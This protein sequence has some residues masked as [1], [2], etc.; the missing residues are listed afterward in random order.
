VGEPKAKP[1]EN[2]KFTQAY[3]NAGSVLSIL[4]FSLHAIHEGSALKFSKSGRRATGAPFAFSALVGIILIT[5]ALDASA[6][7]KL[8]F[9]WRNPTYAGGSFKNI[10]VLAVNGQASRRADFEDAM[11]STLSRPGVQAV[12]SYVFLA[13]PDATPIDP[14][15]L[16][17]IVQSQHFDAILVARLTKYKKTQTYVEGDAVALPP[18]LVTFYGYYAAVTPVVYT[19]GYMQTDTKAQL[20]TNLYS[21]SAEDGQLAWTG[22]SSIV[23]PRSPAAAIKSVVKLVSEQLQKQNLI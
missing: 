20:E 21:T 9:S 8:A 17:E 18:E 16:R 2:L 12:Q 4:L 1:S 13:R 10:L 5:V 22:T 6:G 14:S 3:A 11:V 23:D 19:P 15:N 7:T